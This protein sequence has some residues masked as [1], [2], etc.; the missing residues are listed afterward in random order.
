MSQMHGPIGGVF[1]KMNELGVCSPGLI[2]RTSTST[3]NELGDA[4]E[5][6]DHVSEP[7]RT[8]YQV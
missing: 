1:L 3:V 8:R 7:F 5:P 4:D 2:L 6:G